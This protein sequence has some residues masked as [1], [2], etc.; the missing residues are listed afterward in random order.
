MAILLSLRRFAASAHGWLAK[1]RSQ[2]VTP[3]AE[4]NTYAK[5]KF[6]EDILDLQDKI[7]AKRK[8]VTDKHVDVDF[9]LTHYFTP[10]DPQFGCS[11][12]AR[13]I[14]LPK[15]SIVVGEIHKHRHLNFIMKGKCSVS[16]E[17]GPKKLEAPTIFISEAGT[18]RAVYADEDTIWVT[19]HLTDIPG[20]ENVDKIVQQL[21]ARDYAELGLISSTKSLLE[22]GASR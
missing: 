9:P 4:A 11:T 16:T 13:Q 1:W 14:L 7:I 20:D 22:N 15:G 8:A 18:K 3:Q 17:F 19:V 10:I 5:V 6:R 2:E 21:T 12:Y